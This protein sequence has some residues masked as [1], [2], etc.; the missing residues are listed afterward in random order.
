MEPKTRRP[1][2]QP[3]LY[4]VNGDCSDKC[5]INP[6]R[7]GEKWGPIVH[8]M[9]ERGLNDFKIEDACRAE[10]LELSHGALGRHRRAHLTRKED[11]AVDESLGD[12]DDVEALDLIIKR[13]QTQIKNWKLTPSEFF[14]AMEMKYKL[15]QGSTMDAMFAAMAAAATDR[16]EGPVDPGAVKEPV[17]TAVE[18]DDTS[19]D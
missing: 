16:D 3:A 11:M 6:K 18:D 9:Y 14:K 8:E 17:I 15:T 2:I 12:L 13:G 19:E 1:R 5:T 4:V 7:L 10:G